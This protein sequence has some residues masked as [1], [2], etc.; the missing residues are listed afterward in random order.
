MLDPPSA[1]E[2]P[3]GIKITEGCTDCAIVVN[4]PRVGG[5]VI[6][7]VIYELARNGLIYL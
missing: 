6:S 7:M 1:R 2:R 3:I 4:I 5:V